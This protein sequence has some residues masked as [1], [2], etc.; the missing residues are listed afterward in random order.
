MLG[1]RIFI[2]VHVSLAFMKERVIVSYVRNHP[3]VVVD[4]NL[5]YAGITS[6][7]SKFLLDENE[8]MARNLQEA[9]QEA[10]KSR[11]QSVGSIMAEMKKV[12]LSKVSTLETTMQKLYDRFFT[13]HNVFVHVQG[14]QQWRKNLVQTLREIHVSIVHVQDW[15]M[16]YKGALLYFPK[17]TK[18]QAKLDKANVWM[19][20][21]NYE[22]LSPFI[23]NIQAS[24][25]LL[26]KSLDV[27]VRTHMIP[28]IGSLTEAKHKNQL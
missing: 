24:Y 27:M 25:A 5:A 9:K 28:S 6:S 2:N 4:S 17:M 8:K 18:P 26:Y 16:R 20:I 21:Q 14:L 7:N 12:I 1:E 19:L 11:Q 13:M 23:N 10:K 22:Q 3:V 15:K